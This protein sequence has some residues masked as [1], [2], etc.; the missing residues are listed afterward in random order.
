[1]LDNNS[2]EVFFMRMFDLKGTVLAMNTPNIVSLLNSIEL[3]KGK[4]LRVSE[5][6]KVDVL[7]AMARRSGAVSSNRIGNVYITDERESAIFTKGSQPQSL[8]E[9]MVCGYSNALEL[10]DEVCK[11]QTLDCSFIST[12]HYYIYKDYNPEFGGRYKDSINYIQESQPDGSFKTIFVSAAPEEV[13]VLLDN[14][15]YQ[16]NMCAADDEC[17]KLVLIAAFMFDFMCIHPYNHG[18]G[19]VSRLLLHYLLKKYGYDVVDYFSIAY[20]MEQHLG[21]YIDAFKLSS[22]GWYD[23]E[24]DYEPFVAFIL[25]RILEAY[26]K[27]DYILEVNRLDET[28]EEKVLKVVNDS[29]TPISKT[30]VLRI[31]YAL[32]KVT[33]E[34]ALNKL[35]DEGRIQLITKGRYSKYFRV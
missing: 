24:N 16:F 30:V 11:Y 31:L 3:Y 21:E 8:Q 29:A 34:K 12:L 5:A 27:L 1:M 17:N 33:V 23:N 32:S 26:R 6:K 13:V 7:K 14:L 15:V 10:I 35:V 25:K 22:N 18:N 9:Y 20:L 28:A 19:R 4:T 2:H